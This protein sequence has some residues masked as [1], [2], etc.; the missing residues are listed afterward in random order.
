ML[1]VAVAASWVVPKIGRKPDVFHVRERDTA[2]A[3]LVGHGH[4]PSLGDVIG[5]RRADASHKVVARQIL[6]DLD[7][8]FS[9]AA[10]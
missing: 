2:R 7:R 9:L 10:D 3:P 1:A 8:V 5:L 6:D 4:R